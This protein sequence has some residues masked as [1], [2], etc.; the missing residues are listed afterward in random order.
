MFTDTLGDW[1]ELQRR[2]ADFWK[3]LLFGA[4]I[5][6]LLVNVFVRPEPHEQ[7]VHP[8]GHIEE[9]THIEDQPHGP[10]TIEHEDQSDAHGA[11][12]AHATEDA[13][14]AAEHGGHAQGFFDVDAPHFVL[15]IWPGFWP[16]FSLLAAVGMILV[17][18]KIVAKVL[19]RR[20]DF[21]VE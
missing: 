2:R 8:A 20:E 15:D 14:G 7:A 9:E 10:A 17:L 3:K 21:Y 1:L 12:G 19:G 18:K 11:A 16:A 4:L 13:H 5:L 6:L